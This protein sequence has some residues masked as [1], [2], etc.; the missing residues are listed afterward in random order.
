[1]FVL[2]LFCLSRIANSGGIW[3]VWW[4]L[5]F[6]NETCQPF[7]RQSHKMVKHTQTI[8]QQIAKEL[9]EYVWPFCDIGAKRVKEK[10]RIC[11]WVI[12]CINNNTK[13]DLHIFV[14]VFSSSGFSNLNIILRYFWQSGDY[15]F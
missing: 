7:K 8:C 5:L 15:G 1:M 3:N 4:A 11:W 12:D 2:I 9:F 14:F 6:V 10:Y 13:N